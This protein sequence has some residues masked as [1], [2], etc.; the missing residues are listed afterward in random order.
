MTQLP[1]GRVSLAF[2][3]LLIAADVQGEKAHQSS[4]W[5]RKLK[6]LPMSVG[7]WLWVS[8]S[9]GVCTE[10]APAQICMQ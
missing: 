5:Q 9:R 8:S 4:R 7:S 10:S 1:P 2:I 3:T 6:Q